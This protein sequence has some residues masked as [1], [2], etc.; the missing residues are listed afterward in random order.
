M[1][2]PANYSS[3]PDNML[4]NSYVRRSVYGNF[5]HNHKYGHNNR[6]DDA[7]PADCWCWWVSHNNDDRTSYAY[8]L[9]K[10]GL[11]KWRTASMFA[12]SIAKY[13]NNTEI[14]KTNEKMKIQK[15]LL[16]GCILNALYIHTN[17]HTQSQY[18]I[19]NFME[20]EETMKLTECHIH[21]INC[22]NLKWINGKNVLI[23]R[24]TYR[25]TSHIAHSLILEKY[26]ITK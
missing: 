25:R 23:S 26:E 9:R 13:I 24:K 21:N 18:E 17:T 20:N 2:H 4:L 15:L 16:Y 14:E 5:N 6:N 11:W 10:S 7:A 3:S 12:I 1:L 22:Q 19:E 8:I